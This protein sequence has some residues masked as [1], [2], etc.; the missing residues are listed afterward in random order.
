M[1]PISMSEKSM[2]CDSREGKKKRSFCKKVFGITGGGFDEVRIG[3][4][5]DAG[6]RDLHD[7]LTYQA[8]AVDNV[9]YG[10]IDDGGECYPDFT[11][12]GPLDLFDFL[13]FINEFDQGADRVDCDQSGG[14]DFFDFLCFT[15]AFNEG[16]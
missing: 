2:T 5:N 8:L 13:Q 6:S 16:C 7:E 10:V 11:G 3:G 14:Q 15:N 4:Y 9:S 12:D 1:V